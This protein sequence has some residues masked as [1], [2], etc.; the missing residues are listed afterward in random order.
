MTDARWFDN[1]TQNEGRAEAARLAARESAM[2]QAGRPSTQETN[3][4]L[5]RLGGEKSLSPA[6]RA[7]V[8]FLDCEVPGFANGLAAA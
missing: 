6:E 5:Q 8:S 2:R 1:V 7:L 3:W 4:L